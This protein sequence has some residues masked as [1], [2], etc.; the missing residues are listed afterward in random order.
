VI[1][2]STPQSI[3]PT[4]NDVVAAQNLLSADETVL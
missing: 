1:G 2:F 3:D 4:A